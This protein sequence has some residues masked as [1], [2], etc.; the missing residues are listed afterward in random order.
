MD[1]ALP[2]LPCD[3]L[4]QDTIDGFRFLPRFASVHQEVQGL[5]EIMDPLARSPEEFRKVPPETRRET[6][7]IFL[8][9]GTLP[10]DIIKLSKCSKCFLQTREWRGAATRS[11]MATP[12]SR[13]SSSPSSPFGRIKPE[14]FCR[15]EQWAD[16]NDQSAR[17][18]EHS[19]FRDP[20]PFFAIYPYEPT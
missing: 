14:C 20:C 11:T 10:C 13:N 8:L 12:G 18:G 9:R 17:R 5:Y 19:V 15:G 3:S 1:P 2:W 16:L 7:Y 6:P 4:D